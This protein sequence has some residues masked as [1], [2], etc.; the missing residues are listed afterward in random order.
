M[1]KSNLKFFIGLRFVLYCSALIIV[2]ILIGN[3]TDS[4]RALQNQNNALFNQKSIYEDILQ[5]DSEDKK[6]KENLYDFIK[7]SD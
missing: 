6:G 5:L 1:I 7:V 2:Y 4:Y 3:V